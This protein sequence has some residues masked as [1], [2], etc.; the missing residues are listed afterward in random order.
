[1]LFGAALYLILINARHILLLPNIVCKLTKFE[2]VLVLARLSGKVAAEARLD[3]IIVNF[4]YQF[5]RF[6]IRVKVGNT[7]VALCLFVQIKGAAIDLFLHLVDL[8]N[9][10]YDLV[11]IAQEVLSLRGFSTLGTGEHV[12]VGRN[13]H[14]GGHFQLLKNARRLRIILHYQL[15]FQEPLLLCL[16][17]VEV[18][19]NLLRLTVVADVQD[20]VK[21]FFAILI[22]AV[23]RTLFFDESFD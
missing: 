1:L 7:V 13:V 18:L 10:V 3:N 19:E 2:L 5:A 16:N 4:V 9:D 6:E 20:E 21:L 12:D 22:L 15:L 23:L 11:S 17:S 14:F 8:L